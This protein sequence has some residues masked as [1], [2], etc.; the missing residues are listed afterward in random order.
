VQSVFV[1]FWT[2]QRVKTDQVKRAGFPPSSLRSPGWRCLFYDLGD[3]RHAGAGVWGR[4]DD[5]SGYCF[6]SARTNKR[7]HHHRACTIYSSIAFVCV[8]RRLNQESSIVRTLKQPP[9]GSVELNRTVWVRD[10]VPR[11]LPFYF[12]KRDLFGAEHEKPFRPV[13][14]NMRHCLVIALFS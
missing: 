12:P 5:R 7:H 4:A 1:V 2:Q 3:G 13:F 11:K 6:V 9:A 10:V 8:G 14:G